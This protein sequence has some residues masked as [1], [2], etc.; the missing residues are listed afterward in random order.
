MDI[1]FDEAFRIAKKS[2]GDMTSDQKAEILKFDSQ[3]DYTFRFQTCKGIYQVVV[4]RNGSI[5]KI[6]KEE[7]E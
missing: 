4:E 2:V 3:N 1:G 7:R 6:S 5:A